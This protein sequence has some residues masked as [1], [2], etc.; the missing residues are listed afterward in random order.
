MKS[1]YEIDLENNLIH[2]KH[3]GDITVD[4]EIVLLE[5]IANDPKHHEGMNAI[6]D[7]TEA[8]MDWTLGDIDKFR[9][10][11]GKNKK[12]LGKSRWA[13]VFPKGKNSSTIRLIITLHNSIES[14]LKAK[15]FHTHEEALAWV[16]N[17]SVKV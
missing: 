7:F 12:R 17:I 9:L 3:F 1:T 14:K 4:D 15:F 2:K 5:A 11:V 13:I 6:C 10:F 8:T 16:S